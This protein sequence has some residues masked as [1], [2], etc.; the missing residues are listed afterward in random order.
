MGVIAFHIEVARTKSTC[1][2]GKFSSK[3]GGIGCVGGYFVT[4]ASRPMLHREGKFVVLARDGLRRDADHR[5]L[6]CVFNVQTVSFVFYGIVET[7]ESI[8]A[9]G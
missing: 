5:V 2:A 7:N 1:I 8:G 4:D 3:I 9:R 6:H